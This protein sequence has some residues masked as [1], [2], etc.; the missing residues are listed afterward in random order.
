MPESFDL[1]LI[2]VGACQSRWFA[3]GRH[4]NL[5]EAVQ[6]LQA[7]EAKHRAGIH[8]GTI[9][10]TDELLNYPSKDFSLAARERGMAADAFTV[11][12]IGATRALSA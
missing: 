1:A 10:L 2:A 6:T 7:L 11:M 5:A 9:S 3:K 12:A 4:N 8:W